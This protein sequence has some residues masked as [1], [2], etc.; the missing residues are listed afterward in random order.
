[1][2]D[3]ADKRL[4]VHAEI[5]IST[6]LQK[7]QQLSNYMER[8]DDYPECNIKWMMDSYQPL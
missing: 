2:K 5:S 3:R 1:M 4:K 7:Q 6:S 8:A